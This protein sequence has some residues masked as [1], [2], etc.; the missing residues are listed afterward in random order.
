MPT[1]EHEPAVFD[2]ATRSAILKVAQLRRMGE[3]PEEY[4]FAL[5]DMLYDLFAEP[6][7]PVISEYMELDPS[8]GEVVEQAF[9]YLL[10]EIHAIWTEIHAIWGIEV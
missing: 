1:P 3:V 10:T 6:I 4:A 9:A 7:T 8:G 5:A 2:P